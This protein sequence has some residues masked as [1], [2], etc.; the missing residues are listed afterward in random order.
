VLGLP[1]IAGAAIFLRLAQILRS[2]P[3]IARLLLKLARRFHP[4][5]VIGGKKNALLHELAQAT[6]FARAEGGGHFRFPEKLSQGIDGFFTP[7]GTTR[8]IPVSLKDFTG[9]NNIRNI[10]GRINVNSR[11]VEAAG[12]HGSAILHARVKATA[13][14]MAA[15]AKG[16]PLAKIPSEGVFQRLIF[17]CSDGIVEVTTSRII[18]R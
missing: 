9:T 2:Y 1:Q 5:V 12:H 16:G 6:R 3:R 8:K 10:I 11:M 15:F 4:K 17:E 13:R 14:E 7:K 18:R